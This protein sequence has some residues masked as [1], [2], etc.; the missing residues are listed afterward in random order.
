MQLHQFF[1]IDRIFDDPP[2]ISKATGPF[3]KTDKIFA[4]N[5]TKLSKHIKKLS[6][7]LKN[8]K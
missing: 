5:G 1:H 6:Y 8:Y 3:L 7:T 2:P 4:E